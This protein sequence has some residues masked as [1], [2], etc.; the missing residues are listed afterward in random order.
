MRAGKSIA[1]LRLELI[2][3]TPSLLAADVARSARLAEE[4][5]AVV[6]PDWPPSELAEVL[7][8][9]LSALERR[10]DLRG[11][12]AYYWVASGEGRGPRTLIGSG[13]FHG[14]P[15]A[16]GCI[17]IGYGVLPDFQGRGYATEA[18]AALVAWAL[19]HRTVTMVFAN[20]GADNQPS[21]RLL[22]R[23]GFLRAGIGAEPWTVRFEVDR[24]RFRRPMPR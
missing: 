12:W 16:E 11:W 14:R 15:D 10:P 17:E 24:R 18:V 1:T 4:L 9:L 19:R 2:P 13:G 6:P 7:P 23:L 8:R 21:I 22:E 3:A 20:T 5:G